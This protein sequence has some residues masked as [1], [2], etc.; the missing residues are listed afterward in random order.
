[1][2]LNTQCVSCNKHC[3]KILQ[4][5][6]LKRVSNDLLPFI[7]GQGHDSFTLLSVK[8]VMLNQHCQQGIQVLSCARCIDRRHSKA[9]LS[10]K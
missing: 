1:M 7:V 6:L 5:T 8:D 10:V 9:N 4:E 3:W 2:E